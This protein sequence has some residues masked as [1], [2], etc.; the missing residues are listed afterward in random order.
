[1]KS[2]T[3]TP[4]LT[5]VLGAITLGAAGSAFAG[6]AL[7][8]EMPSMRTPIVQSATPAPMADSSAYTSPKLQDWYHEGQRSR[9]D[10]RAEL[11][12]A[13]AAG[14]IS[15]GGEITDTPKVLAARETMNAEQRDAIVAEYAAER[16]RMVA[17]AEVD[18]ILMAFAAAPDDT[19]RPA[20]DESAFAEPSLSSDLPAAPATA[21]A[22]P[23]SPD[24]LFDQTASEP[25]ATALGDS[26]PDSQLARGGAET[27]IAP[28]YAND[29]NALA[30]SDDATAQDDDDAA[31]RQV[32]SVR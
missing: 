5:A 18:A 6:E 26:E 16:D 22:D 28:P 32:A 10:V 19:A 13:R 3:L 21:M 20:A 12:A 8:I 4:R 2:K 23:A 15:R 25:Q 30:P 29:L 7:D 27:G 24:A 9:A 17:D 11:K 31:D 1:M 14:A